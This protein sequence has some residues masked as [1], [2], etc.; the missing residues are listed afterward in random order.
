MTKSSQLYCGQMCL[1]FVKI[2][3]AALLC[4]SVILDP[5]N[6]FYNYTSSWKRSCQNNSVF[7]PGKSHGQRS[8]AGYSPWGHKELDMTEYIYAHAHMISM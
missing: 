4:G 3:Y 1:Y 2:M 5:R 7:L 8:L 6:Y